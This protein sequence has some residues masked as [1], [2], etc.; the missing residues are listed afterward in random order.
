MVEL[1]VALLV[2]VPQSAVVVARDTLKLALELGARSLF[3]V[4]VNVPLAICGGP[5]VPVVLVQVQPVALTVQLP[6]GRVSLTVTP[7]AGV[8]I[9]ALLTVTVKFAVAG[10]KIA[11]GLALLAMCTSAH[12]TVTVAVAGP[13][14]V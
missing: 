11:A 10:G 13:L 14:S 5:A 4:H 8:V 9:E 6:G 7:L 2:S 12:C 1:T 3:R